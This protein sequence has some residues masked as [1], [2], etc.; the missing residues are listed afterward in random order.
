M[1]LACGRRKGGPTIRSRCIA[2]SQ[3]TASGYW[4]PTI[5]F[6]RGRNLPADA[7]G[8]RDEKG[9]SRLSRTHSS[10]STAYSDRLSESHLVTYRIASG[11]ASVRARTYGR[12]I[13]WICRSWQTLSFAGRTVARQLTPTPRGMGGRLPHASG[14]PLPGGPRRLPAHL[15]NGARG[16]P[17]GGHHRGRRVGRRQPG[18][19]AG[20]AGA[21]RT[22]PAARRCRPAHARQRPDRVR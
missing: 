13:D 20:P 5:P 7:I 12:Y 16:V 1:P 15:P 18:R 3:E 14:P 8:R 11:C 2:K 4:T 9:L 6:I 21:R 19:C 17:A 10:L 22:A